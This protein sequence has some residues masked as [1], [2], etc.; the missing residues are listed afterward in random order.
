MKKKLICTL[1]CVVMA[2]LLITGCKKSSGINLNYDAGKYVKLCDYIGVEYTYDLEEVTKSDVTDYINSKL[3]EK[4]YSEEKEVTDRAAKLGDT[5]NIDYEG[6]LDGTA[7]EGGTATGY[8]L[9]LGTNTFIPGFEDGLVGAKTGQS[10]SLNLTFP[11]SYHS[12]ELAGK[13]VVF[14]VKVNKIT[15][16]VYPEL[17][18]EIVK[19]IS[20]KQTVSE[21]MEYAKEQT[22]AE[23]VSQ[24]DEAMESELWTKIVSGTEVIEYPQD[25]LKYYKD[26][27]LSTADKNAQSQYNMS[28]E[29]FLQQAYGRTL[30]DVDEQLTEQAKAYEKQELIFIA[31]ANEQHLNYTDTE[32]KE[33][34]AKEATAYGY[35]TT[36]EFLAA[37]DEKQF[38]L[39]LIAD[40]VIDFIVEN[41]KRVN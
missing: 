37:I 1:A 29:E 10:L 12:E 21:Y 8:D 18:D 9:T 11:E 28:Y 2:S 7:F 15:E 30:E 33:K 4:S 26:M 34:L 32:Y 13:A 3:A 20:D 39:S 6:L 5:V 25:Q 19:E 31:I 27:L 41:A 16:T 22:E 38:Y 14:N 35:N 17:T 36:K 40:R 24:A 23:K